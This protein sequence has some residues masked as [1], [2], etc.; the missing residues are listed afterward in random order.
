MDIIQ[1]IRY[2]LEN[3]SVVS[4]L[5]KMAGK[6]DT[7][8]KTISFPKPTVSINKAPTVSDGNHTSTVVTKVGGML[9][10]NTK[11]LFHVGEW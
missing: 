1:S 7:P 10:K 6:S 8:V 4:T 9:G 11:K 2:V 5:N 3:S